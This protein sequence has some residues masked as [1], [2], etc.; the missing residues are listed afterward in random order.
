M[1]AQKPSIILISLRQKTPLALLVIALSFPAWGWSQ[2]DSADKAQ[3][4]TPRQKKEQ[5]SKRN[6]DQ[7]KDLKK[8]KT[9][10]LEPEGSTK[11]DK[12]KLSLETVIRRIITQNFD[13]RSARYDIKQ[14]DSPWRKNLSKYD[15]RLNGEVSGSYIRQ[16]ETGSRTLMGTK[17]DSY[18][19]EVGVSKYFSTGTSVSLSVSHEYSKSNFYFPSMMPQEI[20]TE[21]YKTSLTAT[22]Q[23]ALLKNFLGY[24]DRLQEKNLR[25][26]SKKVRSS[27]INS[28]SGQIV[29]G[30][31]D[32]WDL[33]VAEDNLKTSKIELD[34]MQN[35]FNVVVRK[36]RY[37][38][39]QQFEVNQY[40]ALLYQSQNKVELAKQNQFDARI[41]LLKQLNLDNETKLKSVTQLSK[42]KPKI[43]LDKSLERAFAAR[44]DYQNALREVRIARNELKIKKNALLPEVNLFA[45]IGS[46]DQDTTTSASADDLT[47]FENPQLTTGIRATY[48]LGNNQAKT[49]LRDARYDL[50]QAR[51]KVKKLRKDIRDEIASLVKKISITYNI[52]KNSLK[53]QKEAQKYYRN[54]RQEIRRGRFSALTLKEALD[55]YI[56]SRY[57]T[58]QNLI[59]YNVTLLRL[60]LAQNRIFKR[61]GI[62]IEKVLTR[63]YWKKEDEK[64]DQPL[65]EEKN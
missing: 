36:K 56:Q 39:A 65:P 43:S 60:D 40:R 9:G 34:N 29:Q 10:R 20:F 53:A 59:Q 32:Y 38:L 61:F 26:Q 52:Y 57:N 17:V 23:Q 46:G 51:L 8:K 11:G 49:D 19:G 2:T 24:Q 47:T 33:I 42:D 30:L 7:E 45:S 13:V 37:G 6:A 25:L 12:L 58:T 50:R 44:V 63:D 15:Y 4:N 31:I 14:S 18:T 55:N 64:L 62:D 1:L 22:L 48:I 16:P 3:D 21:T 35:L 28:L 5:P 41:K 54:V 27:L